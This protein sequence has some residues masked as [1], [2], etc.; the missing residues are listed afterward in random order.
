GDWCPHCPLG[1]GTVVDPAIIGAAVARLCGWGPSSASR[2]ECKAC[3]FCQPSAIPPRQAAVMG[4]NDAPAPHATLG[5]AVWT[6]ALRPGAVAVAQCARLDVA[7][8]ADVEAVER[9]VAVPHGTAAVDRRDF[10]RRGNCG[11]PRGGL[12]PLGSRSARGRFGGGP[13]VGNDRRAWSRPANGTV[14]PLAA[15]L[16]EG[17]GTDSLVW[18]FNCWSRMGSGVVFCRNSCAWGCTPSMP[19]GTGMCRSDGHCPA[20]AHAGKSRRG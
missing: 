12:R 10:A 11:L 6:H 14:S 2:L 4:A 9:A 8:A 5:A 17:P 19:Y 20:C 1:P 15:V 13:S 7:V 18:R 16:H 3:D